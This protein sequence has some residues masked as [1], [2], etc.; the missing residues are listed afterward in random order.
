MTKLF[1]VTKLFFFSFTHCP[2][3]AGRRTKGTVLDERAANLKQHTKVPRMRKEHNN[4][5]SVVFNSPGTKKNIVV[6]YNT[7]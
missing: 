3:S 6:S 2:T 1:Y 7:P 4:S 5:F